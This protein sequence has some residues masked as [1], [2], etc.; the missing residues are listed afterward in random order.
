MNEQQIQSKIKQLLQKSGWIVVKTIKL[1]E[2][3][4]PDL[5]CFRKGWTTFIEVKANRNICSALQEL[6]HKQ[7]REQGFEVI[8]AKGI[9]DIS[10]LI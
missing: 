9:N 7:L 1:S 6:R 4:Y 5:F 3:G 8:V 10:H 2:S